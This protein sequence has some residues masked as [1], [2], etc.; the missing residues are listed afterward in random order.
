M[1]LFFKRSIIAL[2]CLTAITSCKTKRALTKSPLVPLSEKAIIDQ[3]K[4]NWFDFNTLSAKLDVDA[5]TATE[6]RSFKV[7]TRIQAD[8]AIW[9]SITP[10]LGIEAA[11]TLITTD[12]LK[13]IDKLS[14]KY[15]LGD[16]RALDSLFG[17][18]AQYSFLQNL[19]VGNPIQIIPG[20]KYQSIVDDLYYVIQTRNPRK[21]R[22]AVDLTL[23]RTHEDSLINIDTEIVKEKKLQ[24]A[25]EKFEDEDLVIKRFY[26]RA[27][28]FRVEK[29]IIEDLLTQRSFI[30]KYN[31]F[32]EFGDN[33][34]AH[35]VNIFINTP[36]ETGKFE[37]T[38]SRLKLDE[39]QSYPFKI[40]SKYEPLFR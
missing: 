38:Y 3:L 16:Y 13:F 26:V 7:N 39:S 40:P 28:N 23:E 5:E 4:A 24:K 20:E 9:M 32:R 12:S 31:D 25:V 10:A 14:D 36:K 18:E 27:D 8:S 33:Y 29:V 21:V 2:L 30:V 22:K 34:F 35:E 6:N 37:L 17:Y 11:R 1:M 15:Y 19:L